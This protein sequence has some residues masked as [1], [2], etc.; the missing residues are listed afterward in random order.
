MKQFKTIEHDGKELPKGK[1]PIGCDEPVAYG[2]AEFCTGLVKKE[3]PDRKKLVKAR[4]LCAQ[5]PKLKSVHEGRKCR[6]PLW[7]K[8]KAAHHV[9]LCDA[10]ER[11]GYED[12]E[13]P[14]GI[15][16]AKVS[17]EL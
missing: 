5:C 7:K 11:N 17:A 9:L 10:S 15:K 3:I 12:D 16:V 4:F 14:K 1:C 13:E 2:S 8:W 6:T